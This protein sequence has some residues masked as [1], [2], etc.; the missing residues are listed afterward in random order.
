MDGRSLA[1]AG[2]VLD[3]GV[4]TAGVL[5]GLYYISA[6]AFILGGPSKLLHMQQ[7]EQVQQG[8]RQDR[9]GFSQPANEPVQ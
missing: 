9:S 3:Y 7:S 2:L 1:I 4:L 5:G 8:G 6:S